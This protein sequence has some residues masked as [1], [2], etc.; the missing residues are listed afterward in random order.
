[1][2]G[3]LILGSAITLNLRKPGPVAVAEPIAPPD[4]FPV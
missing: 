1:M 3:L 4:R 2:R